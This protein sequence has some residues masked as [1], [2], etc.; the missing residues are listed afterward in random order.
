MAD[1]ESVS[2]E[3]RDLSTALVADACLRLEITVRM[4]PPG[5]RALLPG[6]AIAGRALPVRHYGSVDVFLEAM[7]TAQPGHV[8][9]IDNAGRTDE[10]CIGDLTALEAKACGV[11]GL[12]VWGLHRDTAEL[13]RIGLPVFSYGACP[14]GPRRLDAPEPEALLSARFGD[15]LVG[16]EDLVFG[17]ADGIVFAPSSSAEEL[18]EVARSISQRERVQANAV[19]QGRTLRDQLRFDEYL[20]LRA[21]DAS[22][23]FRRHLR[24]LGG[25]IEE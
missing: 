8:L 18:L 13:E 5:I 7:S 12:V 25:A 11:A 2:S 6:A 10:A 19:R 17:D 24:L 16:R 1:N 9:V 15:F 14:S 20:R 23:T 22:Y 21:G 4:A 3:F